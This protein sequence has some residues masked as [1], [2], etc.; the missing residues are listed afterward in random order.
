MNHIQIEKNLIKNIE[1]LKEGIEI[2]IFFYVKN[3]N[4]K[5]ILF[6]KNNP[7]CYFKN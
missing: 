7:N 1:F 6:I 2:T 4:N 5:I 3:N